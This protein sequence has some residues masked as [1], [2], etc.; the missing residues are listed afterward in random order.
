MNNLAICYAVKSKVL[1]EQGKE[2]EAALFR[3]MGASIWQRIIQ[4]VHFK[5]PGSDLTE[6][7]Y[8]RTFRDYLPNHAPTD[9]DWNTWKQRVGELPKKANKPTS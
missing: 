1:E 5:E 7:W 2:G 8:L 9:D 4:Q 6:S 3:E